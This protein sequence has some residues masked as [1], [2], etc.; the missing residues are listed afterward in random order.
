MSSVAKVIA[1]MV[2]VGGVTFTLVVL[3]L[4]LDLASESPSSTAGVLI[5]FMAF[6]IAIGVAFIALLDRGVRRFLRK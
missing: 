3:V 2:A 1:A 4:M 6:Y 5:P